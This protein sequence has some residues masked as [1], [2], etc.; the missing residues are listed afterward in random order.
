[1]DAI[2]TRAYTSIKYNLSHNFD[3]SMKD[4]VLKRLYENWSREYSDLEFDWDDIVDVLFA[5]IE[6]IQIKVVNSSKSSE[7]LEYPKNDSLRVIA[8][9]GLS[10]VSYTHLAMP[11]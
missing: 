3:E 9:G 11:A 4:P 5:S 7:R 6:R 1:M 10:P 2:H 8:I